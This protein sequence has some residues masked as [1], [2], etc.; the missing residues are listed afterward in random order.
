MFEVFA[1]SSVKKIFVEAEHTQTICIVRHLSLE[2]KA[3]Q[4]KWIH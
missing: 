2:N 4:W 3:E 1:L